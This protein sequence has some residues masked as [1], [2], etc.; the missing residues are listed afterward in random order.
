VR[1]LCGVQAQVASAAELAVAVRQAAPAAGAVGAALAERR[2][3]KTWAMRGTLHLLLPPEAG[4]YLSLVGAVRAWER[5]VWQRTFETSPTDLDAIA[6]AVAAAL[7][8]R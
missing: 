4:A 7:D 6:G 8:G 1:R 5:P 3:V 2:L